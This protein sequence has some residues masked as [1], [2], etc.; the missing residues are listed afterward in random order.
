MAIAAAALSVAVGSSSALGTVAPGTP[1][2]DVHFGLDNDNATN[3]FIQPAGVAAKLHMDN[4]DVLFGRDGGDLLVGN[5]GSDTLVGGNGP[6]ILVGGP[7]R[8][9]S[10][11]SDVLMG[12]KGDDVNIWAPGDGSDVFLGDEGYDTAIFAP[13]V[14][15]S[16]QVESLQLRQWNGRQIPSVEIDALPQFSCTI[17]PVPPSEQLGVEHLV[18][19][20]VGDSP[21][22]SVRLRQVEQ[23]LCPGAHPGQVLVAD[24]SDADPH[25]SPH[26]L[27]DV[28]GLSGAIIAPVS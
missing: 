2:K 10:P 25:F 24:L 22:V 11:N 13:F 18:R 23:V 4:T 5:K 9:T 1:G 17:I 28:K 3:E 19:F 21:V 7:E 16:D 12:D 14:G 20:N 8:A 15:V 26:P 6:D 27:G